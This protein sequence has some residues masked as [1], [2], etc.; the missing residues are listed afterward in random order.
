VDLDVCSPHP[1]APNIHADATR[2][3]IIAGGFSRLV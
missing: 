2:Y 3:Q 1:S